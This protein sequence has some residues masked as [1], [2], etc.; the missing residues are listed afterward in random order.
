LLG[1]FAESRAGH[2]KGRIYIIINEAPE[3]VYVVDGKL[4]TI[5]KPKRKNKKHLQVIK[6]KTAA[7]IR[8]KL[9]NSLPVS[10]EEI[11]FAIKNI[12][13]RAKSTT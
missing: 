9:L 8:E 2:D 12:K 10:N 13:N 3:Y 1:L 4:K 7:E 6:T 11:K 5:E